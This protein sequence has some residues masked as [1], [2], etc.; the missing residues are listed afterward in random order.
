MGKILL[1]V[2]LAGAAGGLLN[3]GLSGAGL[4]LPEV[5]NLPGGLAVVPGFIG[6]IF[7]G[8]VAAL[9]SFG[10]YGPLAG[11]T[12]FRTSA[13]G[14]QQPGNRPV[15][16]DNL[17]AQSP[18]GTDGQLEAH[19]ADNLIGDGGSDGLVNDIDG[20]VVW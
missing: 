12:L 20:N 14:G 7:V 18:S 16:A 19:G 15:V 2:A 10:L 5:V 8:S 4:M 11:M 17:S 6:N 9:I 13:A 3:A 1:F